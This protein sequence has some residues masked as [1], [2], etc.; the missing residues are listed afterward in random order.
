MLADDSDVE[1]LLEAAVEVGVHV[2]AGPLEAEGVETL[3]EI[4]AADLATGGG[5]PEGVE[6][7]GRAWGTLVRF[8]W[9]GRRPRL[10]P[11]KSAGVGIA[12]AEGVVGAVTADL[13]DINL[14]ATRPAAV[15]IV[16]WDHPVKLLAMTRHCQLFDSTHQ[17]AGQSQSPSG[18]F[19]VI[20]TFP[21]L[22]VFFPLV[23]RRAERTGGM[24][25]PSVL[26][27]WITQLNGLVD[28]QLP[29]AVRFTV[30]PLEICWL[31]MGVDSLVSVGTMWRPSASTKEFLESVVV[32]SKEPVPYPSTWTSW[33]HTFGS[34]VLKVS[35]RI[36]QYYCILVGISPESRGIRTSCLGT[37]FDAV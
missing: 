33:F 9:D 30:K 4:G 17:S 21:Y 29:S 19:A 12:S 2:V 18:I 13:R 5:A 11:V 32:Q 34:R 10:T 22:I 35:S 16:L 23:F 24:V 37:L 20:S 27:L 3:G 26:L 14:S 15:Y 31:L 6:V 8:G 7:G 25:Y 36:R 1:D 28:V